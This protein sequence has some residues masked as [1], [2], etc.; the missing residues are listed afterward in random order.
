MDGGPRR[1][2]TFAPISVTRLD[3]RGL[4]RATEFAQVQVNIQ[5]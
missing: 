4:H 1:F 5:R 3:G 2:K